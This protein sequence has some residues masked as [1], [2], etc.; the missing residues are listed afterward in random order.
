MERLLTVDEAAGAGR[1]CPDRPPTHRPASDALREGQTAGAH[2]G[3]RARGV[4][5]GL[6]AGVAGRRGYGTVRRLASGRFQASFVGPAGQRHN[7]PETF[8]T[9]GDAGRWLL[10]TES[11]MIR[12][13]WADPE[14]GRVSLQDYGQRWIEQRPGLRPRT[15]DL[16]WWLFG[17]YLRPQL[18]RAHRL[19]SA[20]GAAMAPRAAVGRRVR[21]H[22]CEGLPPSPRGAH[23]GGRGRSDRD[24]PL[25]DQGGGTESPAA[26]LGPL[27]RAGDEN[28]T[29]TV[30]LGS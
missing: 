2:P 12:R 6:M 30:S 4:R 11:A 17:R 14:R 25:P 3:E 29:R 5:V 1:Q 27:A 23:H 19:Q 8:A 18:G 7:T 15:V 13:M 22:G 20:T 16:Y 24:E 21:E 26:D 28:R 9:K 10:M